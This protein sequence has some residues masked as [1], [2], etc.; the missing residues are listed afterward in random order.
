MILS[1]IYCGFGQIYR[2]EVLKGITFAMIN[3]LVIASL[4]ISTYPSPILRLMNI[5]LIA[6]MW[7]MGMADA[8]IDDEP[9]LQ[10][11]SWFFRR[12]FLYYIPVIVVF[13]V[14][15]TL[16]F[17]WTWGLL[18]NYDKR[19][20]DPIA[21]KPV[22]VDPTMTKPEDNNTKSSVSNLSDTATSD[23]SYP[24]IWGVSESVKSEFFSIQLGAFKD[25]ELQ[26]ANAISSDLLSK[27]Y[28][29]RLENSATSKDGWN[30]VLVGK[31]KNKKDAISLAEEISSKEK[32]DYII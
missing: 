1:L 27:G 3:S 24:D 20:D 11:K 5:G 15:G 14:I 7:I 4:F 22:A 25:S 32:L 16:A 30:R 17:L 28:P 13:G 10:G 26:E 8:Y 29:A 19:L 2:G 31:F 12:G 21:E 18:G 23:Y 9:T 6:V